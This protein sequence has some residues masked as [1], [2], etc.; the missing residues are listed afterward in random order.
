[1]WDQGIGLLD[2]LE[3]SQRQAM[4][5]GI[6]LIGSNVASLL[7]NFGQSVASGITSFVGA[8]P[9]TFTVILFSILAIY[10]ISR[11][12]RTYVEIYKEKL[13]QAFKKRIFHVF[14]DLKVKVLGF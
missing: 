4:Q 13:P 7:G 11:D 1:L 14:S 10:F 5:E 3:P 8:L 6:Q 12:L 9:L 2:L